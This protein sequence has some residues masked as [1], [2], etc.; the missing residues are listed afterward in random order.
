MDEKPLPSAK[1]S[2]DQTSAEFWSRLINSPGTPGPVTPKEQFPASAATDNKQPPVPSTTINHQ[3]TTAKVD[4]KELE[5]RREK[6]PTR[7]HKEPVSKN[8]EG[9]NN[10]SGVAK[11]CELDTVETSNSTVT[12]EKKIEPNEVRKSAFPSE[13]NPVKDSKDLS[14]EAA[15]NVTKQPGTAFANEL[16]ASNVEQV[17]LVDSPVR[18]TAWSKETPERGEPKPRENEVKEL[19]ANDKKTAEPPSSMKQGVRGVIRMSNLSNNRTLQATEASAAE[20]GDTNKDDARLS[21]K[22]DDSPSLKPAL[23][24]AESPPSSNPEKKTVTFAEPLNES[25]EVKLLFNTGKDVVA[26][27][28]GKK[29]ILAPSTLG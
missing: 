29:D 11:K 9:L 24:G 14:K 22:P 10:E 16:N 13:K 5:T 21:K 2:Q 12:S 27:N 8:V 3:S 7:E 18:R 15:L 6:L 23:V 1:P 17:K 19:E 25:A 20:P 26:G 28:D 4:E